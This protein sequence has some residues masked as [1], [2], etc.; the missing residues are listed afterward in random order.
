MVEIAFFDKIDDCCSINTL[1]NS[2]STLHVKYF[3]L[4]HSSRICFRVSQNLST[5]FTISA[6]HLWQGM[7]HVV[8]Q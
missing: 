4:W 7:F 5:L 1:E 6:S 8:C 3:R 2:L